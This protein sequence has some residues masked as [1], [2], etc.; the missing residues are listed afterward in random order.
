MTELSP[1]ANA[2][3]RDGVAPHAERAVRELDVSIDVVALRA[4][5]HGVPRDPIVDPSR[6]EGARGGGGPA[7]QDLDQ[8]AVG[9]QDGTTGFQ[10]ACATIFSRCPLLRF[11]D[12]AAVKLGERERGS[13]RE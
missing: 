1:T 11:D 9:L 3:V 2:A 10:L 4:Q 12:G 8:R 13:E 7:H 5:H 6:C